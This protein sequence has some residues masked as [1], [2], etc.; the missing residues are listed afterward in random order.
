[1]TGLQPFLIQEAERE[2]RNTNIYL[3]EVHW[4]PQSENQLAVV[5][6]DKT[7]YFYTPLLFPQQSTEG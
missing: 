2:F 6:S 7:V 1:M 5:G 3:K 4:N